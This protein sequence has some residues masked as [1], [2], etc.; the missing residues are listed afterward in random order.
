MLSQIPFVSSLY[1]VS[2]KVCRAQ[3]RVKS[4]SRVS[5][6][7]RAGLSSAKVTQDEVRDAASSCKAKLL[8]LKLFFLRHIRLI[9]WYSDCIDAIKSGYCGCCGICDKSTE[10]LVMVESQI[11]SNPYTQILM[12][13]QWCNIFLLLLLL[14]SGGKEILPQHQYLPFTYTNSIMPI[15]MQTLHI[16]Q[17]SGFWWQLYW[18]NKCHNGDKYHNLVITWEK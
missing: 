12:A 4:H 1:D 14:D 11:S 7:M 3:R 10:G 17:P 13:S 18:Q 5:V 8:M 2:S 6:E 9:Y 16:F 15:Q